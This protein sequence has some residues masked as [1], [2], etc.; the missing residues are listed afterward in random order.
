MKTFY[1]DNHEKPEIVEYRNAFVRRYL[2]D[3]ELYMLRWIQVSLN[4]LKELYLDKMVTIKV[5]TDEVK[6]EYD[7]K[8]GDKR[9]KV[10]FYTSI[11]SI[12]RPY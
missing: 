11:Y 3:Y 7:E 1:T 12:G 5:D 8:Y 4:R 6:S 2:L 9:Q 10:D